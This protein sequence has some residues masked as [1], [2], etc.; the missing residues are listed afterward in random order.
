MPEMLETY[1]RADPP[2]GAVNKDGDTEQVRDTTVTHRFVDD[3]GTT[4]HVVTAGD[5]GNTLVLILHGMPESWYAWHHQIDALAPSY[6]VIAPDMLGYGQSD[7]RLELDYTT[8]GMAAQMVRVVNELGIER[9]HVVAA[10]RGA[11]LA[12]KLFAE[13][14]LPDRIISY[15][16]MQQSGNRPHSEPKPPHDVFATEQGIFMFSHPEWIPRGLRSYL[17]AHP[18]PDEILERMT[19]EWSFPGTPQAISKYF[20][21]TNFDIELEERMNGLFTLMTCPVLF[22]QGSLDPGQQP[23]E[24]ETV[25]QEVRRGELKFIESGHFMHLEDPHVVN[26]TILEWLSR[27]PD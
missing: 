22:L 24:Y 5:P 26:E 18:I 25:T 3:G 15:V 10:D 20:Q 16:R 27:H 19:K 9:F 8:S 14:G 7:K 6:F 21:T 23:H 13:P 11:V 12:D 17:V 1:R 2:P 4:Y